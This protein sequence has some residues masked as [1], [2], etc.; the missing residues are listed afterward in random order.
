MTKQ[1][2]LL[3]ALALLG[4]GQADAA[5]T[6]PGTLVFIS[7]RS[8]HDDLYA[9]SAAGGPLRLLKRGLTE[10]PA[11]WSRDGRRFLFERP[12]TPVWESDL[13]VSGANGRNTRRVAPNAVAPSWAP[14]G[15]AIAFMRDGAVWI[16]GSDGR[17]LRR[18]TDPGDQLDSQPRWSPDGRSI[19]FVRAAPPGSEIASALMVIRPNGRGLHP[20]AQRV[21]FPASWSPDGRR[22]A[23]DSSGPSGS[24]EWAPQIYVADAG[25]HHLRH[26]VSGTVSGE[27]AWSP[28][29]HWLAFD[30]PGSAAIAIVH[31]DGST[32][33][34]FGKEE[35]EN[36]SPPVWS[37]DSRQ[38]ATSFGRPGDVWVFS[39]TGSARRVTAGW[40]YGY[41]N[42]LPSWQPRNL[43][44][45]RLGGTVVS[46]AL[47]SD[48]IIARNVLETTR[49]ITSLAADGA[50]VAIQ[51][52]PGQ[53]LGGLI[54]TWDALSRRIVRYNEAG[55]DGP[56]LAGKRIAVWF[57]EHAAGT[58]SYGIS[59]ATA[60]RPN[61]TWV[62]GLCPPT[63]IGFC[64]RDP[65]GDVIGHGSLLVFDSW[66]GPE[67]YCNLPCP[68]PKHDGRLYRFDN[69]NA[70]EIAASPHG[71]TPRSVDGDRIL[72]DEGSDTLTVFDKT[73]ARLTSVVVPNH[74]AAKM[75]GRDLVLEEN[76]S[77]TDYDADTG[78][79]LHSWPVSNDAVLED[80]QDGTAVYVTATDAH[81]L[82]LADGRDVAIHPP[83]HDPFH[84]QLER[85]GLF[86][87][88]TV[89][90]G[91]LPGRVAFVTSAALP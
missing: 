36:F 20:I 80:V 41:P 71:L 23:F 16:V 83:G 72:V 31:P 26:V 11:T 14:D 9:Q 15:H 45:H 55:P 33:K 38:I 65:L 6:S 44:P 35:K 48:T 30:S 87:S 13:W 82:R 90:D 64:L 85:A 37:P 24:G 84:A 53:R 70:V 28:D 61:P 27:V 77:L 10:T 22:L 68:P 67:P 78:A 19:A 7:Q 52:A 1:P 17:H 39:I 89:D 42:F 12:S 32:L 49:A 18:L 3:V 74:T 58:N 46:P 40:R 59:T 81:L 60:A 34:K 57:F 62:G 47:P 21:F 50:R 69:G 43:P 73:G 8:A 51:Y 66:K 86:Y 63:T 5:S 56:A 29:G 54:E 91:V 4:A 79:L 76:L 2:L 88:Y 75:Q 25:G